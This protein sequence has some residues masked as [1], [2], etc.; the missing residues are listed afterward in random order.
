VNAD[1]LGQFI[2]SHAL[3][4]FS[5]LALIMLWLTALGWWLVDRWGERWWNTA[6]RAWAG[7]LASGFAQRWLAR[8][9]ALRKPFRR[10]RLSRPAQPGRLSH[11]TLHPSRFRRTRRRDFGG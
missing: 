11:R 10:R 4:L 8:F 1:D 2:G 6:L 5:G 7:L 3:L 9:P